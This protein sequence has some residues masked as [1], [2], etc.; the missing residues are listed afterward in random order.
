MMMRRRSNNSNHN[1][2]W[3]FLLLAAVA[4]ISV[5]V[6]ANAPAPQ[7]HTIPSFVKVVQ[8]AGQSAL[9]KSIPAL[10]V[11][12]G[13]PKEGG[14]LKRESRS[15]SPHRLPISIEVKSTTTT[16]TQT[17]TDIPTQSDEIQIQ[18]EADDELSET[19]IT[20]KNFNYKTERMIQR[21]SD[22]SNGIRIIRSRRRLKQLPFDA[23][24]PPAILHVVKQKVKKRRLKV[25]KVPI[26][27]LS[28]PKVPLEEIESS[29]IYYGITKSTLEKANQ[30]SGD[31]AKNRRP[32]SVQQS[33]HEALEELRT[34]RQEMEKMRLEMES[35][36][37]SIISEED[38]EDEGMSTRSGDGAA[39]NGSSDAAA[40]QKASAQAL[41][42]RQK[43][44]D[45]IAAEVERWAEKLI[46]EETEEDGWS[47]VNC[48]KMMRQKLN[49]SGQTK[50][51]I[52]VCMCDI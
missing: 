46:Y 9:T 42:R 50:A 19:A 26:R 47:E 22:N 27:N 24:A 32:R 16:Q 39:N 51:Y 15:Y 25:P 13:T 49:A 41:R 31:D 28:I 36:K 17:Q 6:T 40:Q 29:G 12:R 52:K 3:L 10:N 21:T 30:S 33:M 48:N 4:L 44:Y 8:S 11:Y 35:M 43:E 7:H 38:N 2:Y 1:H 20:A 34:M 5:V 37:Q 14:S 45:K 23:A 18:D